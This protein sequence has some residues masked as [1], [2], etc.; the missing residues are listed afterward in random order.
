MNKVFITGATGFTGI[1]ACEYFIKR[2]YEVFGAVRSHLH[3]IKEVRSVLCDLMDAKGMKVLFENIQP[4]MILHLAAQNHTGQ[5]WDDPISTINTNVIGTMNL[6]EGV[7]GTIPSA[8]ILIIGSVIEFNPCHSIVPN[9]P[10]GLSKYIQTLLST[11]WSSFYDLDIRIA[12]TSNLIGPGHSNGICALLAQKCVQ[13]RN[14]EG[15]GFH[16]HNILDRRDFLDVRDAV[17]AYDCIL[18]KGCKNETYV[19]AS[20]KTYK[21]IEVAKEL[22]RLSQSDLPL[23]TEHFLST[24]GVQYAIEKLESLSWKQT[25]SLKQSLKDTLLY[26][27]EQ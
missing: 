13:H 9:H 14:G 6:L 5:S 27:Q 19:V 16:F 18:Q 3:P 11:S 26:Y 24:P 1:H 23:T 15:K 12:K 25:I 10:Y 22:K 17:S 8:R 7:K 2:G 20:G 4:D 21:F